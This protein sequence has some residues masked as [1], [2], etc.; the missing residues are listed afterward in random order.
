MILFGCGPGL[1]LLNLIYME[2]SVNEIFPLPHYIFR[3]ID[4]N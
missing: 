1:A 3:K 2:K 4:N